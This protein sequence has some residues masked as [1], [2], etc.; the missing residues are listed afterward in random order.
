MIRTA[1]KLSIGFVMDPIEDI[2]PVKDTT[3]AMMLA[4]SRR[5]WQLHYFEVAKALAEYRRGRFE[6]AIEIVRGDAGQVLTPMPE[7]IGAMALQR[8]GATEEARRN[9]AAAALSF[10]WS[11]AAAEGHDSWILHVLRREAEALIV[12]ELTNLL[13]GR[14]EPRDDSTRAALIGACVAADDQAAAARLYETLFSGGSDWDQEQ[15]YPAARVVARAGAGLGADPAEAPERAH[16]RGR[17]R[18][19]LRNELT[20]W[21]RQS[22]PTYSAADLDQ[23]EVVRQ[24]IEHGLLLSQRHVFGVFFWFVVLPGPIGAV[25]YRL[26]EHVSRA[27][28]RPRACCAASASP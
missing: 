22:D 26:A 24:A 21:K 16:F 23:D 3:L 14:Q 13:E 10:D 5:G 11:P 1:S 17:A 15:R 6:S 27:W 18:E 2:K 9:L 12:P 19:W 20:A 7:L 4:A 28:N 25:F 8:T